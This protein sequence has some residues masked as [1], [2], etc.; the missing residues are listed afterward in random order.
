MGVMPS[1]RAPEGSLNPSIRWGYSKKAH[2]VDQKEGPHLAMLTLLLD[3]SASGTVRNK[4]L[5]FM[6]YPVCG[7]LL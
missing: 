4:C 1:K 6:N 2:V 5:L 7:I 3:S